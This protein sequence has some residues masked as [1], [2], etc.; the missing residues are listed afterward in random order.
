MKYIMTEDRTTALVDLL[1][2]Y[3]HTLKLGIVMAITGGMHLRFG[4]GKSYS[5]IRIGELMDKDYSDGTKALQKICFDAKDFVHGLDL[6]EKQKHPGQVL[7]A[8]ESAHL[9][10]A[11]TWHDYIQRGIAGAV[12][13]MRNLRGVA[14]FICPHL[15]RIDKEVRI[16]VSLLG[17]CNKFIDEKGKAAVKMH[18]Y[19]LNWDEFSDHYWKNDP[20]LWVKKEDRPVKFVDFRMQIPNNKELLDAYELK[21]DEFKRQAR[22]KIIELQSINKTIPDYIREVLSK[23]EL[24]YTTKSGERKINPNDVRAYY[25]KQDEIVPFTR[26]G[27]IARGATKELAQEDKEKWKSS[28]TSA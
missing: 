6:M 28:E 26:C 4:V 13:V 17:Q 2:Y 27:T 7:I 19:R 9:I 21:A 3:T 23:T 25:E 12:A 20:I 8:D 22:H 5:A 10:S 18:L 14:I 15:S 24:I 11:Q 1:H 16:Y